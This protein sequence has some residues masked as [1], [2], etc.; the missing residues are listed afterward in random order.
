MERK[1]M[2]AVTE[3]VHGEKSFRMGNSLVD[4]SLTER[5]GHMAPVRFKLGRK[6]VSPYSLAPWDSGECEK[7]T[8]PILQVLRGDF[9]CI[10]FGASKAVPVVHGDTANA[11]WMLRAAGSDSLELG[12]E[13][14]AIPGRV[15]KR[16][17]LE[18]G[19]RA[20]YQEHLL[21]GVNGNF[22]YGHHAILQFPETGFQCRV[23]TSP[24][25][26]GSVKPD[27]FTDPAIG[28][29]GA[30]KTGATFS[31][32]KKV[33]LATG[34]YT[35]LTKYPDRNGFEDLIMVSSKPGNLAWT[36]VTFADYVWIALK[37]PRVL[38]STLFWISNGGRHQKPWKGRH[39]NRMGLEEVC[40]YFCDGLELSTRDLLK[41]KRIP[42]SRQFDPGESFKVRQVHLVHPVPRDFGLVANVRPVTKSDTVEIVSESG[43]SVLAP[44]RWSYA[45][46]RDSK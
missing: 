26:F 30:L 36:A 25:L 40:S 8:P 21:S 45:G 7:G 10:P 2:K 32:L 15:R 35:D 14:K 29:Y 16:I 38:P 19:H 17:H 13:M 34:G 44:V 12:M 11:K 1:S 18:E 6:W 46:E 39:R 5:G 41:D 33:P 31:S 9:F 42:T 3:T 37:D 43:A 23:S 22:N 20:V 24:F 4:L 27:P 28:E